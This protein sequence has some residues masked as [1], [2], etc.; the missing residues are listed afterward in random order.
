MKF[1]NREQIEVLSRSY[2]S[3]TTVELIDM[4]DVQA[5]PTGTQGKI[6]GVDALGSVL[7]KWDNGSML[8]LIPGVDSFRIVKT[9]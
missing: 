7:V 4:D 6:F 1:P 5:P 2:P 9:A 3:G 8:S